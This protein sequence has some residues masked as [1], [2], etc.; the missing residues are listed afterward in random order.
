MYLMV[1]VHN[2]FYVLYYV[3]IYIH[4][5]YTL[6]CVENIVLKWHNA[7]SYA[8]DNLEV[9]CQCMTRVF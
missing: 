3:N 5:L 7:F 6:A 1:N 2:M 9:R 8:L 4:V